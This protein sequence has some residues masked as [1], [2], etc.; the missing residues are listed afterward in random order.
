MLVPMELIEFIERFGSFAIL[1]VGLWIFGKFGLRRV[2]RHLDLTQQLI[3]QNGKVIDQ[4][5]ALVETFSA[6]VETFKQF[7]RE[8]HRT[9]EAIFLRL[10]RIE[11]RPAEG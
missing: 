1:A 11:A 9:H 8:E 3:D 5:K 7:E 6:A 4:N 2:D 10:D